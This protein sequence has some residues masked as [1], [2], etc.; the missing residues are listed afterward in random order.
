VNTTIMATEGGS[1][2]V[3]AGV[4]EMKQVAA[5]F[6]EIVGLVATT[7]D[8][9]REI[10]L[11]TRQQATGV[12]QVNG[13]ITGVAQTT[14]ESEASSTQ[15]LQTASQLSGL[16]TDLMRLVQPPASA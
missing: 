15:M 7:T 14:R 1:K 9:A 5:S 12:E 6:K 2:A 4:R 13:A 3:D 16:A 10:E 8:A 11:S